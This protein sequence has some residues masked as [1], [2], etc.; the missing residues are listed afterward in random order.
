MK[1][2]AGQLSRLGK[3]DQSAQLSDPQEH[4]VSNLLPPLAACCCRILTPAR[5]L[6]VLEFY[7]HAVSLHR[8]N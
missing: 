3:I 8:D 5:K 7:I 1:T 2:K 4:F 6:S